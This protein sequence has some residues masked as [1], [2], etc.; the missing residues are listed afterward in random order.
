MTA[1][2]SPSHATAL[3]ALADGTLFWGKGIGAEG[4]TGGEVCFNTAMTGYQEIMTDPSY[5]GQIITFTF[6]HIGNVGTNELDNEAEKPFAK[7]LILRTDITAPSNHRSEKHFNDWLKKNGLTGICGIDTRALTQH[8]R[9]KGAQNG[10][11]CHPERSEGSQGFF[12][13]AQNDK[14]VE[15]I[16]LQ[17][18]GWPSMDGLDI[19][20]TVS[21]RKAYPWG[22]S[23]GS[24]VVVVDYGVKR[25]ILRCLA[26]EGF[27]LTVVPCDTSA[28]D[29]RALHPDGIFL[30][31]GP[32]D[33]AATGVYAV[34]VIQK[35]LK[36]GLPLFG[37]CLGHQLLALAMGGKTAK[38]PF[39]HR[40]ANHPVKNLATGK[41]EIT[42]QNHGF[43]VIPDSLPDTIEIT[44]TSLFDG[45]NEGL[46]LK[47]RPVFSVQYHPEASP[48]PH[49]S[50]YLFKQFAQYIT[51]ATRKTA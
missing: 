42:S 27:R 20:K 35:L 18:K 39:G 30:S 17:A 7:G 36:S 32:G 15:N 22:E 49:D 31:N 40:G 44:H 29:I 46:R 5:A 6:P 25:N 11:I 26:A 12:A 37:I 45:T 24:H 14:L 4:V 34:P 43:H 48:G 33:P 41:I 51:Q 13:N 3:L 8:P 47:G 28:E 50:H 38:L 19:A 21:T 16:I 10:I 2:H 1:P 9:D 23:T